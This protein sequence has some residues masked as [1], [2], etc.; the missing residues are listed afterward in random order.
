MLYDVPKYIQLLSASI[1]NAYVCQ[2]DV[3]PCKPREY[4][5]YL[6]VYMYDQTKAENMHFA[7]H[8]Y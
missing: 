3:K 1:I 6:S 4:I 5:M 2:R 7:S 8:V